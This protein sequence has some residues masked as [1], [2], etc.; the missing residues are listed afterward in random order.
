MLSIVINCYSWWDYWSF[1]VSTLLYIFCMKLF[2]SY[3][4]GNRSNFLIHFSQQDEFNEE[5]SEN[6][7]A[8]IETTS[9]ISRAKSNKIVNSRFY[10]RRVHL[11]TA[12]IAFLFL[13]ASLNT[14]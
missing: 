4:H 12:N 9:A 8:V 6:Y 14:G 11:S 13:L 5:I 1:Q 7:F 3:R 2:D 10:T